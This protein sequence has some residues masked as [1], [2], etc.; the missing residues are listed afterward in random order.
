MSQTVGSKASLNQAVVNLPV[1]EALSKSVRGDVLLPDSEGYDQARVIWNAM[2]DR[3]PAMIVRCTDE[4]DISECVK[5]AK[6]NGLTLAV[7]GGGHN[8]AGNA[9]CDGGI[10][11]DLTRMRKVEVDPTNR[12]A[13]V[14]PGATLAEVDAATQAHG[15]A[16]P[17]G[18]NS[19]TGIAGLTLGGGFG[20]LSRRFGLTIDSLESARVVTAKGQA[21]TASARENQDLFWGIRGGG[22]NFGVVSLFTYRLHDVGPDVVCGLVVHPFENA[23]TLLRFYREFAPTLPDEVSAWT[24]MRVAPPLPFLPEQWHGKPILAFICFGSGNLDA[25]EAALKPLR[26]FGDPIADVVGRNPYAAWQQT[27][28]PLLTPGARNYWK[29][30]DFE[31]LPDELIET[32]IH[33]IETLPSPHCE[34]F[35]G[36]M[37]G[38]TSRVAEDATAYRD[39]QVPYILNVH[40]R[41]ETPQED[42]ACVGWCRQLYK[43][44]AR[45]ATQGGYVNFMTEDE[46]SRI[47]EVYGASY[48]RLVELK[49]RYDPDNL[50]CM[51]QNI[52]PD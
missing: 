21:V 28:D 43:D 17:L 9:S 11:I 44:C 22:G 23:R 49:R 26:E 36:Q 32:V 8:I 1:V 35:I 41:W 5:F 29:S 39:R 6:D 38:A 18:I 24:V 27:F 14:Q 20:W 4:G 16:L 37:G 42:E 46:S 7:R 12:L 2:I 30:C 25:C 3:R 19:T 45:F 40:G 34:A 13:Y 10:V 33:G 47:R 51:N 52:K 31:S 50:F 15:L 48:D